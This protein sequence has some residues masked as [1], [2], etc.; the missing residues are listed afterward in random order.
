MEDGQRTYLA[1]SSAE[2]SDEH[3]RWLATVTKKRPRTGESPQAM[4]VLFFW[5]PLNPAVLALLRAHYPPACAM[6]GARH[7][8]HGI[9]SL[10]L[11]LTE[12]RYLK[13]MKS[14]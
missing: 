11:K 9:H 6:R 10:T 12:L 14:Q 4:Q 13:T 3:S 8:T 2:A 1:E 5:L 7:H